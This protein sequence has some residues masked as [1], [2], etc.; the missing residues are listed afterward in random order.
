M[1]VF[2]RPLVEVDEFELPSRPLASGIV[3]EAA[4]GFVAQEHNEGRVTLFDLD[5]G[6]EKTITGFELSSKVVD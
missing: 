6:S 1:G 3:T 5:S 2:F 4:R